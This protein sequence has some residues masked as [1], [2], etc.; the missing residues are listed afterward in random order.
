MA[1][2]SIS[3]KL[4][5]LRKEIAIGTEQARQGKVIN[6]ESVFAEIRKRSQRRKRATKTKI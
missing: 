2:E 3:Q 6:G 1:N 4:Q 5:Q